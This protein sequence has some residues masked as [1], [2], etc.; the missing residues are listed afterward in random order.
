MRCRFARA[1]AAP[2]LFTL[3]NAGRDASYLAAYGPTSG[4]AGSSGG[5]GGDNVGSSS[6]S[7]AGWSLLKKVRARDQP[8]SA[9]DISRSGEWIAAGFADGALRV[10]GW[11]LLIVCGWL[12]LI[13]CSAYAVRSGRRQQHTVG[14]CTAA[15]AAAAVACVQ[16]RSKQLYS[17]WIALACLCC[18]VAGKSLLTISP[19]HCTYYCTGVCC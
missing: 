5:G 4:A 18:P 16:Q 2:V 3:V 1:G 7:H 15:V 9:M 13:V 6:S 12:L 8:A 10:G 11:L 14:G 17:V 19:A